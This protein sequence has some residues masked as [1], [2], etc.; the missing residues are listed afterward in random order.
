MLTAAQKETIKR[1]IERA[2]S[3]SRTVRFLTVLRTR[4]AAAEAAGWAKNEIDAFCAAPL[5]AEGLAPGAGG[6]SEFA[7]FAGVA[8][9][10]TGLPPTPA[11]FEVFVAD[12]SPDALRLRRSLA[13]FAAYGERMTVDWLDQAAYPTRMVQ[14]RTIRFMWRWRDWFLDASTPTALRRVPHRTTRRDLIPNATLEQKI[15]TACPQPGLNSEAASSRRVSRRICRRP[16]ANGGRCDDGRRSNAP[17]AT[18]T[19]RPAYAEGVY[20]FFAFFNQ[21]QEK[22]RSRGRKMPPR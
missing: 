9:D 2:R 17:A 21:L 18:I 4:A 12:Q 16:H 20:S 22:A 13:R 6:G 3:I 5:E 15:A 19:S 10:L 8:L 7:V 11:E 14:Q 1:W